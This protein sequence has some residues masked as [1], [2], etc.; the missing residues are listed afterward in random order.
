MEKEFLEVLRT[1]KQTVFI[2]SA[3]NKDERHA[4]TVSSVT[5]L[6]LDPP[7]IMLAINK[8]AG[9][10]KV[11]K[12]EK[13]FCLNL[14]NSA[15]EEI[16]NICSGSEEGEARFENEGWISADPVYLESSQSNIFCKTKEI[17]EFAT[18][19]IVIGEVISVIHSGEMNPLVYQDGKYN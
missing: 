4:M 16:S 7:S 5:S 12:K 6:S 15:Q 17:I 13:N 9:I 19:F 11:L 18:H 2:I 3:D 1:L 8:N 14:L 10:N